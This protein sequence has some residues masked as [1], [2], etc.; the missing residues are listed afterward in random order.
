MGTNSKVFVSRSEGLS[1]QCAWR[2][3][4]ELVRRILCKACTL[5]SVTAVLPLIFNSH[6]RGS[7]GCVVNQKHNC[8][9]FLFPGYFI[10]TMKTY[11]GNIYLS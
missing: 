4:V 10:F 6:C 8:M 9:I 11:E 1:W 2:V 5:C 7:G 3:C